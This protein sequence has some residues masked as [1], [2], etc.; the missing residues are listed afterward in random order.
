MH[1]NCVCYFVRDLTGV[2]KR[3]DIACHLSFLSVFVPYILAFVVDE[4]SDAEAYFCKGGAEGGDKKFN[5]KGKKFFTLCQ[6]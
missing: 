3:G 2:I 6:Y 5:F 1:K 4:E